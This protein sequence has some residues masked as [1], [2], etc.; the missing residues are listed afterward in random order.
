MQAIFLTMT[1][2]GIGLA[3][4]FFAVLLEVHWQK[5][6]NNIIDIKQ[7]WFFKNNR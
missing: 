7:I 1:P 5:L 4:V 2:V 3:S 6:S